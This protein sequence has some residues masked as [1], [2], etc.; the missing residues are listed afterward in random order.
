MSLKFRTT[1]AAAGLL[2]AAILG[3]PAR[4]ET[5]EVRFVRQF[6]MGYLQFNIMER[7]NLLEK[8]AKEEGIDAKSSWVIISGPSAVNDALLSGSV[9]VVAGGVPGLVTLW[10]KTRGT[11]QAVKGIAAFTSQPILLNSRNPKIKT[12]EDFGP[13][14]KIAVPSVK[15]SI[16]AIMVQ[17]AAAQKW[18]NANYAELDPM[19]VAMSPPDATVALLSG[20][21]GVDSVFTVPPYQT[22]QLEQAGVHTVLNSFEVFGGPHTLTVGWTTTQF[23]DK[24]PK[25]YRALIKAWTEA[26]EMLNKDLKPAA[27]YWI[28]SNK[29]KLSLEKVHEVAGGKQV[30]WT[31]APENSLKFAD[32]MHTVGSVKEKASSWKDLF[33]PEIHDLPGS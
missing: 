20:S 29:S 7:H 16:Q 14:D 4:A 33:F 2:A 26:T 9:D 13:N 28:D 5:V 10:A 32:F 12:I 3:T 31:M 24:N 15:V 25:L 17:M 23:H 11:P 27:Q 30:K 1:V 21:T 6:S 18:G 8:Y 19:T 22:Q